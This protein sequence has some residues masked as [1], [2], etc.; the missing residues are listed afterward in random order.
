MAR[1]IAGGYTLRMHGLRDLRVVDFTSGIA[2][3]YATKLFVDA[4]AD[5]IK[6]ESE[7]GDPLRRWSQT[8]R[9]LGDRDGALFRFLNGGKRSVIGAPEDDRVRG[10]ITGAD[11]VVEDFAPGT[12][13]VSEVR[14]SDPSL[15]VLSITPY[16][17]TGPYVGRP[18]TEFLIQAESGS[19]ALRGR[20]DDE[21]YQAGGRIS[22]WVA[23]AFAGVGA[24]A[25][26]L[27]A[28]ETGHG[29]HVDLA[30]LDA[31]N[32]SATIFMDLL[33]RLM[34]LHE[35][36]WPA[37]TTETPSIE[38]TSDGWV[39][40]NTNSGQQF[41]DFLVMIERPDLDGQ[42]LEN[43]AGRTARFDEWQEAVRAWTTQ[44][45]T[46]E[47]VDLASA[48]RIPVAPV[49]DG[50]A[51]LDH[52]HFVAR[53]VFVDSADGTFKQPRR[54][55]RMNGEAP[56]PPRAAPALG[57]HTGKIESRAKAAPAA[58]GAARLPFE[59]LRVLDMTNWWAGPAGT[60]VF[61]SLG[62]DVIHLESAR[63]PDGV[64]YTGGIVAGKIEEWW[65]CSAFFLSADAN[66]RD[67]CL[68]LSG[69]RGKELLERLVRECDLLVENYSPRV[70]DGFGIGWERLQ[71]LNPR[72]SLVRMPA[73][74][75]D[76]PWRDNVGF[77]QTMDQI[78]G[79]AWVTGHPDD[80]PRIQRGPC[81]P[82]SGMNA[83]FASMVALAERAHTGRGVHLE[84]P[85]VEGALNAAAE[86]VIESTAY[87]HVMQRRGNR[88]PDAAPQGIYPCKGHAPELERWF[89][90]SVETDA[91]WA[92][93][94]AELGS[95]A[96][97]TDGALS[98]AAGRHAG[99]DRIDAELRAYFAEHEL[100]PTVERLLQAGVPA[101]TV[102]DARRG[103]DHP[104]LAARGFFETVTHD[105]AG[106]HPTPTLP[107]RYASVDRWVQRPAPKLG[108]HNREILC[109]LLGVT[110]DELASL[111]ADGVIATR[112]EGI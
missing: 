38:P 70:L 75:L 60:H 10:L 107:F 78:S 31:M 68:D 91:Q 36:P 69:P 93:L 14:A 39:G 92:A 102:W 59:G 66:K 105:I 110:D 100:E 18:W 4:G 30:M 47:V 34:G 57:E 1:P 29:E 108:E 53:G 21:P 82:L 3:P 20:P 52:E 45:T 54:P 13:D 44:H 87:G 90:L 67:L 41:A 8:G 7:G 33:Y 15:V 19:V 26:V 12:F 109:D 85:M 80:Q 74:G 48:L 84:C 77:A 79:L 71:E 62:A 51:V 61:A 55:Y 97:A 86:Q 56:A 24:L 43:V 95:P 22:D 16:G 32:L 89:A 6:V 76:G 50:R 37:R 72:L 27:R 83:A 49:N 25:A 106:T 111:E 63:R 98:T 112:P 35:A 42:G 9:D 88:A 64:R 11:L 73:F 65:E 5:V 23:G 81:D 104:Q 46:Q 94:V 103:T 58:T 2:G 101:G 96:W 17:Q 28:R 40:F 99:H